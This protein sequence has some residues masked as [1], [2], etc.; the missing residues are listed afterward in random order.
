[1]FRLAIVVCRD[2]EVQLKFQFAI[3]TESDDD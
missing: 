2:E 3:V 1:M